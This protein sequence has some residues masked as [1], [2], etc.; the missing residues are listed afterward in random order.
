[1]SELSHLKG[2]TALVTGAAGFIGS[3]L[4]DRLLSLGCVVHCLVRKTSSLRW[5]SSPGI[6]LHFVDLAEP[7]FKIPGLESVDYVFHCA[8]LTRAKSRRE[9]FDI[10]SRAC[11]A[12]YGQ[13][14]QHKSRIKGIVHLSS[15]AAAGPGGEG[16]DIDES[17][18]LSPVTCYGESKKSGEEAALKFS[19]DLPVI[20][21]RP[22]VVYGPREENFFAF[23]KLVKRGW[24]LQIGDSPRKLS[25]IYVADLVRAVLTACGPAPSKNKAYF[26]TDGKSYSWGDIA[27]SAAREM[28]VRVKVFRAPESVLAPAALFFEA[29]A[30]F[31]SKPAL[32]DRQR[33]IDI[34]QSRWTAS[35]ERFFRDFNFKP[36]FGLE[37]GL[38]RALDW[39]VQEKW[40]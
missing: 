6:R 4:V 33:M 40:L 15:L 30:V 9:Y 2:K 16:A 12:L 3:H 26:V 23:F 39:C 36:E 27:E 8:G 35:P 38:A 34:R 24:T 28:N 37:A 11:P 13:C 19:E 7:G 22:P 31:R 17:S 25:L 20:V 21:L 1:M 18:P 10:N 14:L 29:L 32:L 5:L